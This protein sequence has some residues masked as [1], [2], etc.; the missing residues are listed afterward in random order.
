MEILAFTIKYSRRK[1]KKTCDKETALHDQAGLINI[2]KLQEN[3]NESGKK[4]RLPKHKV[5]SCVV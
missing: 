1:E 2:H 3:C 4:K 5:Q